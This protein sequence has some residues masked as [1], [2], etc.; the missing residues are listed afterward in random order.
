LESLFFARRLVLSAIL[1][2]NVC[3]DPRVPMD[4]EMEDRLQGWTLRFRWITDQT[5]LNELQKLLLY[6]LDVAMEANF[7][8]VG[9]NVFEPIYLQ[10]GR[11]NTHAW[12]LVSS[13]EEFVFKTCQK[14]RDFNAWL[15]L[16]K[17]SAATVTK[18]LCSCHD[19]QF[20]FLIKDRHVFS[21]RNGVYHAKQDRF[22]PFEVADGD[23][24]LPDSVVAAKYF[25]LEFPVDNLEWREIPTP[26]MQSILSYQKFAP[27]VC[28]WFYILAGRMIYE[29][30]EMDNWQI[31]AFLLGQAGS[32]KSTLALSVV[33]R[34]YEATD[35][36]VL[37]NNV[38]Q[39]FGISAFY[40]KYVFIAPEIKSDF[41]LSQTEFQSMCSGEEVS[42][43]EKFR[44]AFSVKWRV[45]GWLCGN[46]VP[47]WT[48][49][50]GSVQRRIVVFSFE[51][52]VQKGDM[53]LH[54]KLEQEMALFILKAN[55][56]YQEAVR[57][58]SQRNIWE[59]LPSYFLQRR[60]EM[61]AQVNG[62]EAFLKSSEVAFGENLFCPVEDFKAS[63]RAFENI[64]GFPSKRFT[65]DMCRGPF[66][67]YS[68]SVITEARDYKGR[69]L[70][71]REYVIG[72]DLSSSEMQM[73]NDLG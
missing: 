41:R 50:S 14:E 7:R 9:D 29:V 56:A 40:N 22:Y 26:H 5:K 11:I 57:R 54:E 27:E 45:P 32:G 15:W 8:K 49:N 58:F 46:E 47:H 6:V 33:A 73:I 21:F 55:K 67:K 3:R 36:G 43:A 59:V 62:L 10:G 12:R 17:A 23:E 72:M 70:L 66:S 18:F 71:K 48:D 52:P 63:L 13:I 44:T 1:C 42:I 69:G 68:L 35:V 25:D 31:I 2:N 20:P 65:K 37:S 19:F 53:K 60:E 4:K 24:A 61:A 51:H 38:E 64:N 16:T 30:G 28:D 39:Q 34:L